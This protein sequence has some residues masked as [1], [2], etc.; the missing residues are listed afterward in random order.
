M[1]KHDDLYPPVKYIIDN[2]KLNITGENLK[3]DG[4][5]TIW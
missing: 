2:P 5:W 3:V 4:G 1:L